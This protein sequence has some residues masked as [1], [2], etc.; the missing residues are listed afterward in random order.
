MTLGTYLDFVLK[1]NCGFIVVLSLIIKKMI[2][3]DYIFFVYVSTSN[4]HVE[5]ILKFR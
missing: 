1:Y 2:A 4:I 5:F 3:S